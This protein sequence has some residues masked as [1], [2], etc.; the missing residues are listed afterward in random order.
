MGDPADWKGS[1]RRT[2]L[3]RKAATAADRGGGGGPQWI[4]SCGYLRVCSTFNDVIFL[5]RSGECNKL[6]T[7]PSPFRASVLCLPM[8]TQARPFPRN[9]SGDRPAV[10]ELSPKT[11]PGGKRGWPGCS[12][13]KIVPRWRPIPRRNPRHRPRQAIH[14]SA[15]MPPT[16]TCCPSDLQNSAF[17]NKRAFRFFFLRHNDRHRGRQSISCNLESGDGFHLR[18]GTLSSDAIPTR[19][20]ES[21]NLGMRIVKVVPRPGSLETSMLPPCW[22]TAR[23]AKKSPRPVPLLPLEE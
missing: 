5:C 12:P 20:W 22:A 2:C 9:R 16:G 1:R 14:R 11:I 23:W 21:C 6:P 7:E 10:F 13:S 15:T 3:R 8:P 4:G 18:A 19:S 17:S